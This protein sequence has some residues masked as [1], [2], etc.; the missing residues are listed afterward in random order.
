M[1]LRPNT[2][3]ADVVKDVE[4]Y[5]NLDIREDDIVLD[6]GGHIGLF[7]MHCYSKAVKRVISVEPEPENFEL[8]LRNTSIVPRHLCIRAAVIGQHSITSVPFYINPGRNKA[9]HTLVPDPTYSQIEVPAL[10]FSCLV[11]MIV[12]T[13]IKVDCEGAE[14]GYNWGYIPHYIKSLAIEYHDLPEKQKNFDKI[15]KSILDQSFGYTYV[16]PEERSFMLHIYH[17]GRK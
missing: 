6:I 13:V 8:H 10:C 15:H 11:R 1:N 14:Y 16:T 17:R 12:P 7:A 2:S 9:R 4:E 5:K 3:D